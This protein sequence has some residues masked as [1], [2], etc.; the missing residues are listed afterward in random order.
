LRIARVFGQHGIG[1]GQ[2]FGILSGP[3]QLVDVRHFTG[4][5]ER[6]GHPE[7]GC[8]QARQHCRLVG[9]LADQTAQTMNGCLF[10]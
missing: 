3:H 6:G 7:E 9:S 10:L 5:R 1:L 8:H 4:M 2:C